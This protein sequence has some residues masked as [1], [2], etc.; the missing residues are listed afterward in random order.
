MY[1]VKFEPNYLIGSKTGLQFDW[2]VKFCDSLDYKNKLHEL[3]F[4]NIFILIP[5]TIFLIQYSLYGNVTRCIE[6]FMVTIH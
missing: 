1:F 3:I 4:Y 6:D 5:F 2:T